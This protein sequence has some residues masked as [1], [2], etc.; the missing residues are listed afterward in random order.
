MI[1]FVLKSGQ[2]WPTI[3]GMFVHKGLIFNFSPKLGA[4]TMIHGEQFS[5]GAEDP[6]KGLL[7]CCD[8]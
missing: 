3:A 4:A 8:S 2:A 1:A 7:M 5:L 6:V